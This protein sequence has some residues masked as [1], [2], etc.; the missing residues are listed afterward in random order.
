[1][2][3]AALW[4]ASELVRGFEI[5][6]WQSILATAA[7]FALVNTFITPIAQILGAP[8]S[9]LTLGIFALVI[10]AL[11]LLLTIALAGLFDFDVERDGFLGVFLA[12]LLI[13]IV[14]WGLNTFVGKPLRGVLR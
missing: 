4:L 11:M 9:C 12:A 3:A 2:N 1:V 10:N 5:Q 6:G 8:I 14:S 13:S 7:I